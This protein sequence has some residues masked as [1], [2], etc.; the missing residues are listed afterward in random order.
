MQLGFFELLLCGLSNDPTTA[1]T[2][3]CSSQMGLVGSDIR[4]MSYPEFN[5]QAMPRAGLESPGSC[6]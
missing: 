6:V 5:S 2:S 4:A 3:T 1:G